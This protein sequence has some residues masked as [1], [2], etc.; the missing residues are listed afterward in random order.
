M[1]DSVRKIM[2]GVVTVALAAVVVVGLIQ[3]DRTDEDRARAIGS[4]V[5][6]PVCQGVA[7]ADSPSETARAMMDVVEE[8]VADGWS[9]DQIIDYFSERYTD[10][11]VIDPPFSGNTLLVW[12]LPGLAVVAGVV[13]IFTRRKAPSPESDE[14]PL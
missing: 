11:I 1:S 9:D 3:G 13:M 12:L 4:R 5:K 7:I 6:C 8:R 14:V 10:S 2:A